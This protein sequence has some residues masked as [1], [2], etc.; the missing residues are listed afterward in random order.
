[1]ISS[2]DVLSG[3]HVNLQMIASHALGRSGADGGDA[4]GAEIARITVDF[5]KAVKNASAPF[6]LVENDPIVDVSVGD[7]LVEFLLFRGGSMRMVGNSKASA[8]SAR[9]RSTE[10]CQPACVFA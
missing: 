1:M 5:K 10:F 7:E 4:G 3:L 9:K 2:A 6:G 8:P